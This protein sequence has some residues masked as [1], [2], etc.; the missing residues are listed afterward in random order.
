MELERFDRYILHHCLNVGGTAE[1]F[2]AAT[3]EG[4]M[5]AL[6]RPRPESKF[7]LSKRAEFRRGME[8]QQRMQGPHVARV[9]ELQ[10]RR[11]IPF[12][13]MEFVSGISLRQALIQ[14]DPMIADWRNALH[15]FERILKGVGEIHRCG[16]MHLDLKP[17][18]LMLH[19]SGEIKI[20]DFDLARSIPKQAEP[21]RSIDGT[22][23]YLAPEIL[24]RQ[25]VDERSDIFALGI[26]GYELFTGQKP[27]SGLKREEVLLAY[28]NFNLGFPSP[29]RL[30]PN[31]PRELSEVLLHCVSKNTERRYPAV[32]VILRDLRKIARPPLPSLPEATDPT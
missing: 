13:I 8:I 29:L 12:A 1:V 23:A 26:L 21:L 7:S 30:N 19:P 3:D 18:N 25:P 9:F 22:P 15:V 32:P 10:M 20:L 17:E 24:L 4:R 6:R 27:V 2:Q 14:K 11:L 16:C 5:V 31:L 28:S